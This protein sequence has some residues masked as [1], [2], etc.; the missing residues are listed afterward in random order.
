MSNIEKIS[1][2]YFTYSLIFILIG[3]LT[4]LGM[5]A[6]NLAKWA[7][8]IIASIATY[9]V[10]IGIRYGYEAFNNEGIRTF[11]PIVL[12]SSIL[13]A[14]AAT[15]AMFSSWPLLILFIT[16]IGPAAPYM[17][18]GVVT[19]ITASLI[20]AGRFIETFNPVQTT[21]E[22]TEENYL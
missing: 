6:F 5:T 8:P 7:N 14:L 18:I 10:I 19:T 2:H 20:F 16:K 13:Y 11:K 17:T 22:L 15:N 3:V 12:V 21:L 9:Q 4:L 1:G